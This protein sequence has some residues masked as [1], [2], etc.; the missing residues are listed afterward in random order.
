MIYKILSPLVVLL[1]A[2]LMYA[3]TRPSSFRYTRSLAI[4]AA[5]ETLFPY[6]NDVHQFQEWN[7]FAEEDPDSRLTF[8]GPNAGIDASCSWI[9]GK[10]GEGSMTIVESQ[11]NHRVRYRM[12]FRK[13]FAATHTAEFTIV[14]KGNQAEVSWSLYGD[15][16]FIGKVM[17]VLIDCDKM[18]GDQFIK[19]LTNLKK[20]VETP[21]DQPTG[22]P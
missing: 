7:P 14:P 12:D 8:A 6:I 22:Q 9:G 5:P 21:K 10:S 18:C 4:E 2:F 19:G 11:P 1:A 13:P 20:L 17:S 16:P 15:N 3:S